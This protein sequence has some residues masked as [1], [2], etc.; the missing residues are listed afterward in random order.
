MASPSVDAGTWVAHRFLFDFPTN[1]EITVRTMTDYSSA[2]SAWFVVYDF[3]FNLLHTYP[4]EPSAEWTKHTYFIDAK[5]SNL[6]W[7]DFI[8]FNAENSD[9]LTNKIY[10][11]NIVFN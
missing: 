1:G 7:I 2:N 3:D 11:D 6:N 8:Y 4:I 10:F 9:D 5:V